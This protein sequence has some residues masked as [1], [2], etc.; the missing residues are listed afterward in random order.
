MRIMKKKKECNQ[1]IETTVTICSVASIILA[2][3]LSAIW[4][5][6]KIFILLENQEIT[7]TLNMIFIVLVIAF[8]SVM[9]IN[10][11]LNVSFRKRSKRKE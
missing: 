9:I 7:N 2:V 5:S 1:I 8:V 11:I 4:L 6:R 10:I 3:L